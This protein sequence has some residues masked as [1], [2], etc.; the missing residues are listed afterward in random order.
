MRIVDLIVRLIDGEYNMEF[1]PEQIFNGT[2]SEIVK[3]MVKR[4][5]RVLS[6][7][8]IVKVGRV[9]WSKD[10]CLDVYIMKCP[11]C[12]EYIVDY[13]HGYS[14]YNTCRKCSTNVYV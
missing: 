1:T 2:A 9:C 3:P 14:R 4:A 7:F 5:C 13:I 12:G 10:R 6:K 8:T 11:K